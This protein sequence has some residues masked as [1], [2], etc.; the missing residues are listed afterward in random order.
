MTPYNPNP[1]ALTVDSVALDSASFSIFSKLPMDIPGQG[2]A[3]L[4]INF[5]PSTL[6][7]HTDNVILVTGN[8]FAIFG[9]SSYWPQISSIFG[10]IWTAAALRGHITRLTRVFMNGASNSSTKY[11]HMH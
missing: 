8:G 7:E 10:V 11:F 4:Y 3:R 6:G 5:I 1:T 2:S 9:C